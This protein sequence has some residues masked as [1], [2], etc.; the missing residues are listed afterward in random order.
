MTGEQD[1]QPAQSADEEEPEVEGH[2]T[3]LNSSKSNLP[4]VGG[5]GMSPSD[6]KAAPDKSGKGTAD[7]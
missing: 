1:I 2:A 4:S 3:N 5:L 6:F 7:R